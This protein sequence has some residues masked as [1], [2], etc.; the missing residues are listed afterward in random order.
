MEFWGWLVGYLVLF[1]LLHALLYYVYTRNQEREA[2]EDTEEAKHATVLEGPARAIDGATT[3]CPRC[4][5][6]NAAD[7]T[8]TYC[9]HC[10]MPLERGP[11][12]G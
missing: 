6:T 4:G 10:I 2:T 8:F 3:A 12:P 11:S 7:P 5:A 1:A 9:W